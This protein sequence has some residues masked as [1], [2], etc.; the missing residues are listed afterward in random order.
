MLV[1]EEGKRWELEEFVREGL[2]KLDNSYGRVMLERA[3]PTMEEQLDPIELPPPDEEGSVHGLEDQEIE[4]EEGSV[5]GFED[6][7]IEEEESKEEADPG[8]EALGALAGV[9]LGEM[10]DFQG[11]GKEKRRRR[12]K[13]FESRRLLI[14]MPSFVVFAGLF[15]FALS[16]RRV[17]PDAYKQVADSTLILH[18]NIHSFTHS[19]PP[20]HTCV[21]VCHRCQPSVLPSSMRRLEITTRRRWPTLPRG[22]RPSTGQRFLLREFLSPHTHQMPRKGPPNPLTTRHGLLPL[23][24]LT[25]TDPPH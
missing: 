5:H 12:I 13:K 20:N 2:A 8:A 15:L 23:T 1:D 24:F 18:T 11:Q 21:R 3:L 7:E 6:R 16:T 25:T 22:R 9:D 10:T 19:H 4:D 14:E 17:V